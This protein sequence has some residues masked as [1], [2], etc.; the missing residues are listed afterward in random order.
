MVDAEDCVGAAENCQP[1][2]RIWDAYEIETGN[3]GVQEQHS[4]FMCSQPCDDM[5]YIP[6]AEKACSTCRLNVPFLC[7][8]ARGGDGG[9][10]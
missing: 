9:Y 4:L 5:E 3:V 2:A 6:H 1:I 8:A 10:R 7:T